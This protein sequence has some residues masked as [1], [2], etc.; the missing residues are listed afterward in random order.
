MISI[1]LNGI[2][3]TKPTIIQTLEPEEKIIRYVCY[4]SN[5][6]R[7]SYYR[8]GISVRISSKWT[9]FTKPKLKPIATANTRE[10]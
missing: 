9:R 5:I 3:V 8:T 6:D 4:A 10:D 7:T 2:R 1:Y